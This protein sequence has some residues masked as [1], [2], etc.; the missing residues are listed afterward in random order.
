MKNFIFIFVFISFFAQST[1]VL[2]ILKNQDN[3]FALQ[4]ELKKDIGSVFPPSN[5]PHHFIKF[6]EDK[7]FEKALSVWFQSIKNTPFAKSST[8]SALY[9]YLLFQNGF[10]GLSLKSLLE[11]SRPAEINP[12]V[13]HLWT[14]DINKKHPVWNHFF[15]PVN[16]EWNGFFSAENVFKF[17]S[18]ALFQLKDDQETIKALLKLPLDKTID[19]FSVEWAFV[20]SLI[21][22]KDMDS[23]TKILAWLLKNT[24]DQNKKDMIYLTI[25]RLLADIGET[26]ASLRYYAQ[27]KKPSY[28]WL[29]AQ[30]EKAW[31][32][33]NRRNYKQAYVT[34]SVFEYPGFKEA[35]NP[36]MFF[37]LVRSQL[38]N[39]DYKGVARTLFDFKSLFSKRKYSMERVLKTGSHDNLRNKLLAFYNSGNPY[40]GIDH[41]DLFYQIKKDNFLKNHIL[42]FNYMK[43]RKPV[44]KAKIRFLV[45]ME[46]E[47]INQLEDQIKKRIQI[48]MKKEIERINFVLKEF[49]IVETGA[50]YRMHGFHALLPNKGIE[51]SYRFNSASSH[52]LNVLYFPFDPNEIWLDELS[53]YQSSPLKNCPKRSYIL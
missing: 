32:L 11:K 6:F 28:F 47:I 41:S 51:F 49:Q 42:L 12:I 38:K 30:E 16:Q 35:I 33:F 17:S 29:F 40:Y 31:L 36:Y 14:V 52:K 23:A 50:L 25:G 27:L 34:A 26:E 46:N 8:G 22:R 3:S 1:T 7:N 48:L 24:K 20:L 43:N 19:V 2:D 45:K 39:C 9:A 10:E 15:F 53:A 13:S 4:K 5:K 18:K 21:Q 44:G 37:V